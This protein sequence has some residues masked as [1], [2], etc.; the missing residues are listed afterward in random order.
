MVALDGNSTA[1][2]LHKVF[3]ADL[4]EGES[5]RSAYGVSSS[6]V[7]AVVYPRRPERVA[8]CCAARCSLCS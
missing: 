2:S 3:G 5:V 4:I 6:I 8:R 7:E 1:G